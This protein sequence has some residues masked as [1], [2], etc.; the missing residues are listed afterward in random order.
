MHALLSKFSASLGETFYP[1]SRG[2]RCW[3]R[4]L[5]RGIL[6]S[7]DMIIRLDGWVF[8]GEFRELISVSVQ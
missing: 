6:I 3:A 1:A 8:A 2:R 4:L 7:A 5:V